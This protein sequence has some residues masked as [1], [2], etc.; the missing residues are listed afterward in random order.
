MLIQEVEKVNPT[1][2][3]INEEKLLKVRGQIELKFGEKSMKCFW[4][5]LVRGSEF[6]KN[7]YFDCEGNQEKVSLEIPGKDFFLEYQHRK[8]FLQI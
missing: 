8:F 1:R 7:M 6:F 4:L 2:N 3:E 5:D